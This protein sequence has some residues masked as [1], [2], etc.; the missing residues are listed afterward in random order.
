MSVLSSL[1]GG[2]QHRL[3]ADDQSPSHSRM[4]EGEYEFLMSKVDE[5]SSFDQ[6]LPIISKC[7]RVSEM[8]RIIINNKVRA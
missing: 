7:F 5:Q 4:T 8:K 1:D 6:L 3:S 2:S